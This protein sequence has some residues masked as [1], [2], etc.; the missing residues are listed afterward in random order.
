MHNVYNPLQTLWEIGINKGWDVNRNLIES[1]PPK[2]L[3][4]TTWL[5]PS[6]RLIKIY[7]WALAYNFWYC[8]EW[9]WAKS[10]WTRNMI[11]LI[12][13]YIVLET[14]SSWTCGSQ[15]TSPVNYPFVWNI[16]FMMC[17]FDFE[18]ECDKA[19]NYR[20]IEIVVTVHYTTKMY[21]LSLCGFTYF[22]THLTIKVFIEKRSSMD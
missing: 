20:M 9:R 10:V 2:D 1:K 21:L 8:K 22:E 13:V 6:G 5:D 14:T 12:V 3:Q 16:T 7:T 17:L 19:I 4:G 18:T 11:I 15:F